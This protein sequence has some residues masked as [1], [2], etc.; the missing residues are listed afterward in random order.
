VTVAQIVYDEI[1]PGHS[2]QEY[3]YDT[4]IVHDNDLSLNFSTLK[5]AI[6]LAAVAPLKNL[7]G[8][9][10][11]LRTAISPNRP[12]STKETLIALMKRNFDVPSL[13]T[14][15]DFEVV[16][17]MALG[18]F[19][20]TFCRPDALILLKK[21]QRDRAS[22]NRENV[23]KWVER[24]TPEAINKVD[25]EHFSVYLKETGKY[26][27]MNKSQVKPKCELAAAKEYSALQTV[28]YHEKEINAVFGPVFLEIRERFFSLLL[29]N[30]LIN[31]KKNREQIEEFL[32]IYEV[33]DRPMNYI[34]NDFSKFDKS[35]QWAALRLE[36][37][38]YQALGLDCQMAEIWEV[39]HI[40]CSM[41]SYAAG[42]KVW[43]ML[44]RLSGDAATALGNSIVSLVTVATCYDIPKFEYAMG[45][46]DDS[47]IASTSRIKESRAIEMMAG[48]FNLSAK[49]TQSPYGFFCSAFIV[50]NNGKV[51]YMTDPVKRTEKLG[52]HVCYKDE[53][54]IHELYVSFGDLL[55]N[56][57]WEDF[58]EPLAQAVRYRYK[59]GAPVESLIKALYTLSVD[60]RAFRSLYSKELVEM[61]QS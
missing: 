18:R 11:N 35:Q 55:A 52:S 48:V 46:G 41:S 3:K 19:L 2:V 5:A 61:V 43:S 34:E 20:K 57:R 45:L 4:K 21:Y 12:Q 29:P 1:F 58:H 49:L 44:Q 25:S 24:L 31:M 33:F 15:N 16:F 14:T 30:V 47:V 53:S 38:M 28:V 51:L 54:K 36:W 50:K 42:I 23:A 8:Y 10:P 6:N 32:S 27:L 13:A 9:T 40:S 17:S 59:T 56:Y 60:K 39:G 37:R 26:N 7:I 22:L